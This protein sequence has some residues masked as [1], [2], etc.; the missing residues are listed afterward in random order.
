MQ[1]TIDVQKVIERHYQNLGDNYDAFLYHSPEYVRTLSEKMIKNLQLT[2]DDVLADIG[3][4]TGIYALDI[5]KQVPL[6]QPILGVDPF[7]EMISKI[8][9]DAHITPIESDALAFSRQKSGYNKAL[10][11]DI[12]HHLSEKEA[13]FANMYES[14][15]P[16]GIMLLVHTPPDFNYPVFD[17]A[18]ERNLTWLAHPDELTR[19]M[20]NV[21]FRVERDELDYPLSLPKAHYFKMLRGN[22][23]SL[24]T[25]FSDAE[26]EAGIAEVEAR[27]ADR[28]TVEYVD[29]FD[30]LAAIKPS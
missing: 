18:R 5:L 25:S 10:L 28:D 22:C 19:L 23:M 15:P 26:R 11:K 7:P 4:G 21:G 17:A 16:G 29:H 6:R 14:L 8:P 27:Y 1:K 20:E 3:C 30:Y 13:F 24:M 9:A 12:V 2:P